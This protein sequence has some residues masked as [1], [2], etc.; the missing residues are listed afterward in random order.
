MIV[1]SISILIPGYT[2]IS[3]THTKINKNIG[4]MWAYII[5]NVTDNKI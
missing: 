2:N 5:D 4:N 1:F 3:N